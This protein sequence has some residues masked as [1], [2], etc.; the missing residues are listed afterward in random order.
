MSL[1]WLLNFQGKRAE[2]LAALSHFCCR[3]FFRLSSVLI[4]GEPTGRA[5]IPKWILSGTRA[6]AFRSRFLADGSRR[7]R[8]D[9][10]DGL[11]QPRKTQ[12]W[13]QFKNFKDTSPQSDRSVYLSVL[14]RGRVE[15]M[16]AQ[17]CI[18]GSICVDSVVVTKKNTAV[19][20]WYVWVCMT[21][22]AQRVK[23]RCER[24]W[25]EM[26][27]S[28]CVSVCA[29]EEKTKEI[30]KKC[31]GSWK[32]HW[33]KSVWDRNL[34]QFV[35][36]SSTICSVWRSARSNYTADGFNLECELIN[37]KLWCYFSSAP[38]ASANLSKPP[39]QSH[40]RAHTHTH[41][42]IYLSGPQI[43]LLLSFLIFTKHLRSDWLDSFPVIMREETG[44]RGRSLL[45]LAPRTNPRLRTVSAQIV[46][47]LSVYVHR[48]GTGWV[49]VCVSVCRSVC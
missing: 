16:Q 32:R 30:M 2:R 39:H 13:V 11:S 6:A 37:S 25:C 19:W 43:L 31:P 24:P 12:T 45:S 33:I 42:V 17:A 44:V 40:T 14:Q 38:A 26:I 3:F 9:H 47:V 4:V 10:Y 20:L 28:V 23:D 7:R 27:L 5:I 21:D 36:C 48:R 46:F 22:T 35:S 34:W 29:E 15:Q 8:S 49:C 41:L 18:T 1:T